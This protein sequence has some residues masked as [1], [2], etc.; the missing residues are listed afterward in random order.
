MNRLEEFAVF[1]KKYSSIPDKFIDDFFS[2]YKYNTT[3]NDII[4][5][6][7][8][9]VKWL[10]MRKDNLK[11][12]LI[13]SY[14]NNVD[15][16][17]TK[18]KTGQKGNPEEIILITPSCFK[19]ICM[20]SATSKGEEVR[21]YYEKIEHLLNK[22]KDYIIAG[23]TKRIDVLENNQKPKPNIVKGI[24]YFIRSGLEPNNIFKIGKSKNF[25]KRL[26]SHNSSHSDDVEI[27]L[28]L[29][30]NYM[31]EVESCMKA[32]LKDKQYRNH[33][34]I[35]QVDLDILKEILHGCDDLVTKSKKVKKTQPSRNTKDVKY[36]Y[37][38]YFD[39][40]EAK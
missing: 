19:H 15:Y 20:M 36:N 12:T 39:K 2:F 24:I 10:K 33:K 22:Y 32:I 13:R 16:S 14:I 35:F 29:E 8:L 23:L 1:L 17:I 25:K 3:D 38:L 34:E 4:I 5:N 31:D 30:T 40:T 37:Y 6:F 26:Q 7:D 18:K 21:K 9:V 28:V 27:V 11:R